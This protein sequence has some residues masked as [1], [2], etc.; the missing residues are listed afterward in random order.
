MP[1]PKTKEDLERSF[2]AAHFGRV[3]QFCR[4]MLRDELD[5]ED[6]CQEVFLTV[7]RRREDLRGVERPLPWLMKIALLTCLHIR[8]KRNRMVL[9]IS[10]VE[11]EDLP[12]TSPPIDRQEDVVRIRESLRKL[13]PRFQAI[14]TLHYQQGLT[15][16]EISEVL[17]VSRGAMRVLLHRAVM[18]LRQEVMR[19]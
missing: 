12:Q 15:H 19:R 5:V 9:G 8:R 14:L 6:A 10:E 17:G 4:T 2:A 7:A 11:S 3:Y 16:E 18:R 13:P 1:L